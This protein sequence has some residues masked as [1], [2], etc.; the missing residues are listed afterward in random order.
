MGT[1]TRLFQIILA[2]LP[3]FI[4]IPP[5][6]SLGAI[7]FPA[8]D[9]SNTLGGISRNDTEASGVTEQATQGSNC[10]TC[11]AGTACRLSTATFPAA[12]RCTGYDVGLHALDITQGE[13]GHSARAQQW[14]DV[15]LDPAPV[16]LER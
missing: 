7:H 11:D 9:L 15:G 8:G 6:S 2:V 13:T 12:S 16:H 1:S 3:V 10:S 14:L 4:C 5:E